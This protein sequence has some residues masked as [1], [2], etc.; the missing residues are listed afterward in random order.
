MARNRHDSVHRLI[1][2]F[3][4]AML[5]FRIAQKVQMQERSEESA[6]KLEEAQ[7]R[8]DMLRGTMYKIINAT[9]EEL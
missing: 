4:N 1:T 6:K 8:Y 9:T 5:D 2:R 3:E 7:R